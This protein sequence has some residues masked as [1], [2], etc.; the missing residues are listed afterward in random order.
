MQPNDF[1]RRLL[2]WFLVIIGIMLFI[3]VLS[4]ATFSWIHD[5][6]SS[7]WEGAD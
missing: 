6:M 7:A 4:L 5:W 3:P 2:W 1:R